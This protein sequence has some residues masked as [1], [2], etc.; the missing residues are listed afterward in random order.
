MGLVETRL[1]TDAEVSA[2]ID[3]MNTASRNAITIP[4][5]TASGVASAT[6]F[7]YK[8]CRGI[9][10]VSN[11]AF[12]ACSTQGTGDQAAAHQTAAMKAALRIGGRR[13]LNLYVKPVWRCNAGF[14][15]GP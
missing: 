8:L 11:D 13:T 6:P 9:Q 2:Q 5:S 1:P 12:Y 3:A 10:R 7:E 15:N 4:G 14:A